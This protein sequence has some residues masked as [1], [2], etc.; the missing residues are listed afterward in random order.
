MPGPAPP[1]VGA[2]ASAVAASGSSASPHSAAMASCSIWSFG[3]LMVGLATSPSLDDDFLEQHRVDPARRDGDIDAARQL[4]LQ[5]VE[6][7]RAVEIG[8]PQLA[9]IGLERVHDARHERL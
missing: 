8:R 4:F 2:A 9:Q 6:A 1:A 3:W 5:P 7:G